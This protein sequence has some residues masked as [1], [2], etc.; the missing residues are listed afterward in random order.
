MSC[1]N[2]EKV[3]SNEFLIQVRKDSYNTVES[4]YNISSYSV[5]GIERIKKKSTRNGPDK[6]NPDSNRRTSEKSSL[7]L[8]IV[9]TFK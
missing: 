1:V 2:W 8:S 3:F 9:R 7:R 6:K 5:Y 4:I